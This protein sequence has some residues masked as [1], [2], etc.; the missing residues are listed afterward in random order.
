MA[1]RAQQLISYI[2]PGAPATRQPAAG[3][4]PFLRPEIGFTPKWYRDAL[5]VDFGECWHTDVGYRCDA[6][7]EMRAELD[8]RFPGAAI[9]APKFEA[10]AADLLTGVHGACVVAGIYGVPILYRENQWPI[11]TGVPLTEEEIERLQPPNLDDNPFFQALMDQVDRI[12]QRVG[13]VAGYINWQ[14]VLNNAHR[15]RG[16]ELFTDML[17]SPELCHRLFDCVCTT[18]ADAASRLHRRQR[19]SG[20]DVSFFTVS[21]C[22][23]NLV[24]PEQ[25]REF[26]FP[27]DCRLGEKFDGLGVHNCAW[28]VDPYLESYAALPNV[29]Y[30]DMGMDS[31]LARVREKLPNARRAVMY[32]PTML[33]EKP[34]S[35][36]E[37]DLDRICRELGPCDL[38]AADIES[39]TDDDRILALID[40]C[41]RLSSAYGP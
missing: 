12:A 40:M 29:A 39:G 18:M 14:G 5:G 8:R 4:E 11:A 2:A 32:P 28:C 1:R 16:E 27:Y 20:F 24:S 22:L 19:A 3:D 9:G 34:L 15:L 26:L 36:I 31:D 38:V 21:N 33:A 17:T 7:A 25:Y 10:A 23:V 6:L 41:R 30:I 35:E 13:C 37:R